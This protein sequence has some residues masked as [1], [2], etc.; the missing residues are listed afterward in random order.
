MS[1]GDSKIFI[2]RSYIIEKSNLSR[3][4][5]TFDQ[6]GIILEHTLSENQWTDQRMNQWVYFRIIDSSLAY[7]LH[8]SLFQLE[9]EFCTQQIH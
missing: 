2:K 7:N 6:M 5:H 8:V 9:L 1:T 3:A 4:N